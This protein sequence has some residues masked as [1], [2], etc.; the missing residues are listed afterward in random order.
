MDDPTKVVIATIEA[1]PKK[2]DYDHFPLTDYLKGMPSTKV[3]SKDK[4]FDNNFN[5]E[6]SDFLGEFAKTVR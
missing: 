2:P 3:F 6:F 1:K 4:S 5:N